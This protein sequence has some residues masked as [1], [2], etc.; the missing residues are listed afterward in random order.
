MP[1]AFDQYY[2]KRST[3]PNVKKGKTKMEL[4]EQLRR[5]SATSRRRTAAT[6][7]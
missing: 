6:A 7:W 1:A 3:G 2:V 5:T 4:A